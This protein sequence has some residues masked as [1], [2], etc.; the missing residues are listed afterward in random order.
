MISVSDSF[1]SSRGLA[2]EPIFSLKSS[3]ERTRPDGK[4]VCF[5]FVIPVFPD[6][7]ST[8]VKRL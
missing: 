8:Y 4:I 2:T 3:G 1:K 6:L 5:F 7:N